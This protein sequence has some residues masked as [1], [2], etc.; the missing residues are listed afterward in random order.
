MISKQLEQKF[1][2][3]QEKIEA[4]EKALQAQ[5]EK[6]NRD[7]SVLSQAERDKLSEKIALDRRELARLQQDFQE[8][9]NN[10]QHQA[11]QSLFGRIQVA[12]DGIAKQNHYDLI[13]QKYGVPYASNSVDITEQVVKS[14]Q[15]P[16]A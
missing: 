12:I 5:M 2:P 7:N 10:A 8:D 13:L 16:T 1:K 11:M 9:A 3:R 15:K 4:A 14:L 6:L